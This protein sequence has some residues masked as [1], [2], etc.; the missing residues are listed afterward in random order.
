MLDL[1]R[2][3]FYKASLE[4]EA[5]IGDDVLW[6]VV[7]AIKTWMTAKWRNTECSLPEENRLW[8]ALMHRGRIE[9]ADP[10][11]SVSVE[12]A[13]YLDGISGNHWACAVSETIREEGCASREWRSEFGFT[14]TSNLSGTLSIVLTYGDQPGFLGA[15]QPAPNATVPGIIR[16]LNSNNRIKCTVS[17]RELALSPIQLFPGQFFEFWSFVSDRERNVPVVFVSPFFSE[18]G[19]SLF[20]DPLKLANSLG[21]TAVVYYSTER[22]FM[23]EMNACLPS[24]D[25]RCAN[26]TIRIYSPGK[27]MSEPWRHRFFNRQAIESLGGEDAV[28]S[29][30]RRAFAQDVHFYEKMIRLED[31][32]SLIRRSSFKNQQLLRVSDAQEKTDEIQSEFNEFLESYEDALRTIEH[33]EAEKEKLAREKTLP[34]RKHVILN[35]LCP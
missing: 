5:V 13:M 29:L 14:W 24:E 7:Y 6:P 20:V 31:V 2:V 19:C 22:D 3:L 21:P 28:I 25:L 1:N 27:S 26:G 34:R 23:A 4:I 32:K 30:L 12:S 8:G 11:K 10:D 35:K 9:S 18:E 15:V 16:R 33:L 17:G